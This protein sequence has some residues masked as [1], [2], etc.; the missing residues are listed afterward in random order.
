M[1]KSAVGPI[2]SSKN[3]LNSEIILI[4]SIRLDMDEKLA[5]VS[6][7]WITLFRRYRALFT[8]PTTTLL[9]KNF[10]MG[11]TALFTYLKII[12]LQCFQF[13]VFNKINDIQTDL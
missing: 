11:L 10:K 4:F 13:S 8:G 1:Q 2:H 7:T 9:K 5:F 12:L 6:G 3:K